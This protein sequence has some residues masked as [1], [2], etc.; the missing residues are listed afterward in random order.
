MKMSLK[1]SI[2]YI[3]SLVFSCVQE[4]LKISNIY[5]KYQNKCFYT[6]MFYGKYGKISSNTVLK[7][8][9]ILWII[10]FKLKFNFYAALATCNTRCNLTYLH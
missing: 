1:M 7:L 6:N 2:I 3:F 10:F 5:H 4:L 9:H 8:F